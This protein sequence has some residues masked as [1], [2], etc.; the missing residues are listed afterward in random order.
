MDS[1]EVLE[2]VVGSTK[3][4]VVELYDDNDTAE[5]LTDCDDATFVIRKPG[6][7]ENVLLRTVEDETLTIQDGGKLT[8]T[9]T[10]EE[11]DGLP[12]ST[13][14]YI[15]E[16]ALHFAGPNKWVNTEPFE[17]LIVPSMAPHGA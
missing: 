2:L 8:F 6:S 16:L 5:D 4:G 7:D 11:A 10:Q 3:D 13:S 12:P 17:V 9:L 15:G 1:S 14:P